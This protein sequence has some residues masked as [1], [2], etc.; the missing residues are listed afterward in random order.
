[1]TLHFTAPTPAHLLYDAEFGALAAAHP[2]FR[3]RPLLSAPDPAWPGE[4]GS[5]LAAVEREASEIAGHDVLLCGG[6]ELVK[7]A[8]ELCLA[9]G[10][11]RKRIRYEKFW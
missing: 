6:G 5:V 10:V 7:A 9:H 1:M 4:V 11:E 8:R 3:Y 2:G